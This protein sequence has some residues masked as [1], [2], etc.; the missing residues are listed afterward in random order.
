MF[1]KVKGLKFCY[2]F[3]CYM[4]CNV[5]L[6][7]IMVFVLKIGFLV[8]GQVL[9][10][11]IFV[12]LGMGKFFYDVILIQDY[13]VI[14]G[15]SFVIIFMMVIVVFFVDFIYLLIDLCIWYGG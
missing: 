13:F 14:Q 2:I 12:Y 8:V 10:E 6:F 5:I 4:I 9:V 7:Q 3:Y 15:V 11:W 1:V